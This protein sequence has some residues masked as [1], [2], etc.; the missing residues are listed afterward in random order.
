MVTP[1]I[2]VSFFRSEFNDFLYAPIGADR[3]EM[4]LSVL[5]AL[6]RLNLDPWKEAAEL[7]ELPKGA[8]RQRL[9][10]LIAR[11]PGGR[12]ASADSEAIADRLIELLPRH[13]LSK[14]SLAS[15]GHGLRGMTGAAK[16]LIFAALGVAAFIIAAS[17]EPLSRGDHADVPAFSNASPPQTPSPIP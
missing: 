1:A 2:S 16:I 7:S 8:A 15:K 4:P 3:N 10:A 14:V 5:S 17:R 11:L 12:W 6:T 9:A 13:G